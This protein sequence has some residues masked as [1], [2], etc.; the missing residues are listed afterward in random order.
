MGSPDEI[1]LQW[2]EQS[3]LESSKLWLQ[4]WHLLAKAFLSVFMTQTDVNGILRRG[5]MYI[6]SDN[7]FQTILTNSGLKNLANNGNNTIRVLDIGAGDGEVT[8]RLVNA[9]SLLVP[10][11]NITL[12]ATESSWVMRS[13]LAEKQIQVVEE[14]NV[15]NNVDFVSCLNVLDRCI[16]PLALLHE[17]YSVL[18]PDGRLMVALVLPYSHYV[19]KNS[20]HLPLRPLLDHW[21]NHTGMSIEKEIEAF[22]KKLEIVGFTILSW[23]K[24]PYLCEGDLRQSFYWLDDIVVVC[25][26]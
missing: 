4:L 5:S 6:L 16:D 20:S 11:S 10:D 2:I 26:K 25:S 8:A 15:L 3:R 21:P 13:R 23:T 7:Q 12:F 24:A 19:E 22:F 1:T 18:A 14:I 17:I 9:I